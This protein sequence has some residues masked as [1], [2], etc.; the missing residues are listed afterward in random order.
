M[1]EDYSYCRA[2]P[3]DVF[4][5][6]AFAR[7]YGIKEAILFNFLYCHYTDNLKMKLADRWHDHEDGWMN[8]G[9]HWW[10]RCFADL[11]FKWYKIIFDEQEH[12]DAIKSLCDAGLLYVRPSMTD[13]YYWI[14]I[15]EEQDD[16]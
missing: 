7:K 5:D 3:R 4:F 11:L 6:G 16:G 13:G 10:Q 2:G 9:G 14:A 15:G 1:L 8:E 12:K